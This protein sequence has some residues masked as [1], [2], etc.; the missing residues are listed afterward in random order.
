MYGVYVTSASYAI[1]LTLNK[2]WK[3]MDKE[4]GMDFLKHYED[5]NICYHS[6]ML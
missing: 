2:D 4:F 6:N 1:V 5:L 3:H